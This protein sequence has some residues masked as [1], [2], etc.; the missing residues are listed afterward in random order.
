MVVI[1]IIAVLIGLLLPALRRANDSARALRCAAQLRQVGQAIYGYAAR[2][3]GFTP[4]WGGA[5]RIDESGDPLSRGWIAFL[6]RD[7]GVR[8]DS[9][10]YHCPAF[11]IADDTVNYF[12]TAHWEH[13]QVPEVHSIQLSRI[14][15]SS[16]FLLV[17]EATAQ[18]AYISP[19]G[20]HNALVDNK[21][22]DDSGQRDLIFWGESGGYNM[23][24]AGNNI[25]FA[26][27]HVQIFKRHEPSAITYSP[28]RMENWDEVTGN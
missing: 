24:L 23:H 8:A 1:G 22:K 12:L 27:G 13:L 15:T 19:F 14:R 28:D 3:R 5:F 4:P 26:D 11:P 10:L 9:P 6:A 21:D 17:A 16:Q 20:T 18:N 2:N 7:A 25:L